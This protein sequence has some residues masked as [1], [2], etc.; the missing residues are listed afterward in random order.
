MV[1][2]QYSLGIHTSSSE[3]GL[4]ISNFAGDSRYQSWELGRDLSTQLHS[5]LVEFIQ[6]QTWIDFTFLA[7]AI[8]PGSFTGTRIGVVTARTMAQQLDIPL[9]GISTLAAVVWKQQQSLA[10][11]HQNHAIAV[12][13]PAQR[14]QLFTAI[15]QISATGAGLTPL[16]PDNV[17]KPETWQQTLASF[18]VDHLIEIPTAAGLGNSVSSLLELAYLDW[19]QGKRPHWSEVLPYYGQ[20]PVADKAAG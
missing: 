15:Y 4:T 2:P 13:M 9:F 17:M 12:Q 20:H 16:L 10:S 6:P 19:Q 8:G 7:V 14:E 18:P 1:R 5:Y 11:T 3:L